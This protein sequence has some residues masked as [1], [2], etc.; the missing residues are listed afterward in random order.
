MDKIQRAINKLIAPNMQAA[1]F[2]LKKDWGGFYRF[3][4]YGFEEFT[5]INKGRVDIHYFG[6]ACAIA[7]RH[8]RIQKTFNT[9]GFIYGEEEQKQNATFV[10][11]Y[12][13]DEKGLPNEYLKISPATMQEDIEKVA[14]QISQAFQEQAIPF[15]ATYSNLAVVEEK[16]NAKPLA[17]IR[18]Y[19]GDAI[20]EHRIVTSLICAKAVNT[21]RYDSVREACVKADGGMYPM[22]KRMEV[23]K[24]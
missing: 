10:L 22:E 23:L 16:L 3:T 5:V 6:I 2:E 21:N 7:V 1:G 17:D 13:Y 14:E 24:K 11:G 15:Y 9:F 4:A 12:P 20:L 8:D 19:T 18:P